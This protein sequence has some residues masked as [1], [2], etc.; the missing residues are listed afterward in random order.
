MH[1]FY[2][3]ILNANPGMT[4]GDVQSALTTKNIGWGRIASNA[5]VLH[6]DYGMPYIYE[7]IFHLATP[8][9]VYFLCPFSFSDHYG[10]IPIDVRDWMKVRHQIGG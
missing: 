8:S 7:S 2:V 4:T 6:T 3:L 1:R 9:G 10:M 5:W